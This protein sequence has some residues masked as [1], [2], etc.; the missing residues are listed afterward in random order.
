[1]DER[2]ARSEERGAEAAG[3]ASAREPEIVDAEVVKEEPTAAADDRAAAEVETDLDAL[4]AE[5]TRERDEHLELAQRARADFE[6]YRRRVKVEV[7]EA[8]Q[9]GRATL[10]RNVLPAL[11]NLERAL[12]AAGVDPA[13]QGTERGEAPSEEVSARDALAEGVALVYRELSAALERTG[14]VAFDPVGDRFDPSQHE[15]IATAEADGVESGTVIETLE[16]GYRVDA[17][18]IRPARVVVSG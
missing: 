1:M 18:V 14:V 13:A 17:Q 10:A 5:R 7:A 11:D 8:E 12:T 3:A 16:R 2:G 4:L 15:A 6:N 9:R